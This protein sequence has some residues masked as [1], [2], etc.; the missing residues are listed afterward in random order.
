MQ[1]YHGFYENVLLC[2]TVDT[3]QLLSINGGGIHTFHIHTC[4]I[5]SVGAYCI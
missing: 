4:S 2:L 1:Y 5:E 3:E